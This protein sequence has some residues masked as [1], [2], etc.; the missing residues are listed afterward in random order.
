LTCPPRHLGDEILKEDD[1]EP[2]GM[3]LADGFAWI[4][5]GLIAGMHLSFGVTP[6]LSHLL[7]GVQP[8]NLTNYAVMFIAILVV[9]GLA[10]F[11][12]TSRAMKIDPLT[13]LRYE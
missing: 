7:Y 6:L 4:L 8:A 9:G 1:D 11:L 3:I 2:S 10:A 5:P 13:A 12:P